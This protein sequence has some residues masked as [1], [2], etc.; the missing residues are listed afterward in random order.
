MEPYQKME[1]RDM[2]RGGRLP[3]EDVWVS[4]NGQE[5]SVA[6]EFLHGMAMVDPSGLVHP[7]RGM[8]TDGDV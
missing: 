8:S 7:R 5:F 3:L 6:D 1:H 2:G 4:C